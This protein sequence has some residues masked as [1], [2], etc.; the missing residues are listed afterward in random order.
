MS[1][2]KV[3]FL[4]WEFDVSKEQAQRIYGELVASPDLTNKLSQLS[5]SLEGL[6]PV[7]EELNQSLYR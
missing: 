6:M 2:C 3:T 7:L 5:K 4:L 1:L